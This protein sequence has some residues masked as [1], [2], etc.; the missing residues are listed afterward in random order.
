MENLENL[1][2]LIFELSEK[3]PNGDYLKLMNYTKK[4]YDEMKKNEI[5]ISNRNPNTQLLSYIWFYDDIGDTDKIS[6]MN[7]EEKH[8]F[9]KVDDCIRLISNGTNNKYIKIVKINKH[10][11]IYNLY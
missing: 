4:I 8:F 6:F 2:G 9:L 11:I 3:I 10:S 7:I 5:L 1:N